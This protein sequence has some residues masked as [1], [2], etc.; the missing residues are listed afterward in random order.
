MTG[1]LAGA[2]RVVAWTVASALVTTACSFLRTPSGALPVW[3][4]GRALDGREVPPTHRDSPPG[5]ACP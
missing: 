3:W 2:R 5:R 4:G 1:P